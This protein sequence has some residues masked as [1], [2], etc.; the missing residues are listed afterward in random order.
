MS[1]FDPTELLK[2]DAQKAATMT[3][4]EARFLV[5]Q[6]YIWQEARKRSANQ[7]RVM[8]GNLEDGQ[9]GRSPKEPHSVLSWTMD[10]QLGMEKTL[11]KMLDIWTDQSVVGRWVKSLHG[12]GPIIA[13]GL[14]AHIDITKA[15]TVGHIWSFAGLNPHQVWEKGHT[16]PWNGALKV[17]AFKIGDS[18]VKFH[19]SPESFYGPLYEKRKVYEQSRNER[20]ELA[21]QALLKPK[22]H[23]QWKNYYSKGTLPPGHIENRARRW[24]EKL[25]FAHY[26]HVAF[27]VTYGSLPPK[28]YILEV[29]PHNHYVAPPNWPMK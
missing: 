21:E 15:P 1:G 26:H 6:Y 8:S 23:K 13:A 25:F 29:P 17:L 12:F 7:V 22:T 2:Y 9:G 28:P 16:R 19:N 14:L 4:D 3:V 27:E 10:I 5:D 24:I 11:V 20:G 18:I